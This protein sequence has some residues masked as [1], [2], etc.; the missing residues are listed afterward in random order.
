[1]TTL[2]VDFYDLI[3]CIV[4]ERY[5]LCHHVLRLTS[6]E[7]SCAEL[8]GPVWLSILE[9]KANNHTM[10]NNTFDARA[11]RP[12]A[13]SLVCRPLCGPCLGFSPLAK[14]SRIFLVVSG[15]KSSY[16]KISKP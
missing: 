2:Q 12:A 8:S 13:F 16:I 10:A 14:A 7:F 11:V 5:I 15:V 6:L 9:H 3:P 4:L 1:M